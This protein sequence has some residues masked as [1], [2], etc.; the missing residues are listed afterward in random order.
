MDVLRNGR[1]QQ[2]LAA[3][4]A[5]KISESSL[6]RGLLHGFI[7]VRD[8]THPCRPFIRDNAGTVLGEGG[9][10]VVLESLS[11][12]ASRDRPAQ[13][14]IS[15]Y[16]SAFGQAD[17]RG[18]CG[19]S[20]E[21]IAQAM[22]GALRSSGHTFEEVDL[23][24]THGEG[25]PYADRNEIKA[26]RGLMRGSK[27]ITRIYS[28]KGNLGHLLAGAP[29][30]DIVLAERMISSGMVPPVDCQG[31]LIEDAEDLLVKDSP[32]RLN[33]RVVMVNAFSYE[34]QAGSLLL[35]AL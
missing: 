32:S 31:A 8:S 7:N 28:S 25:S 22:A 6:A 5:E 21:A 26:I 23:V 33:P 35:E 4:V 18:F 17:E 10:I 34:G 20:E 24:L 3:G 29:L 11:S 2:V 30:V 1:N 12:A 27:S 9:G 14:A 19:P 13:V 15:G 16:G